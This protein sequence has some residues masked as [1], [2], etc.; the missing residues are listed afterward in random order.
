MKTELIAS[1]KLVDNKGKQM[2]IVNTTSGEKV[3]ATKGQFDTNAE[4]ISYKP[5]KIGDKYIN[6]KGEEA[7]LIA[8][9]NEFEGCGRQIVKKYDAKE[10]LELVASKGLTNALTLS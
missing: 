3:W 1:W 10:L 6:S 9:R 8:D 2:Y 7:K 5:M 4:Q